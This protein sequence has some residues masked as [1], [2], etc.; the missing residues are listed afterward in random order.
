MHLGSWRRH[1]HNNGWLSYRQLAEQLI[2]YVAEMGFTH[3]ELLPISEHPFDGSWGYQPIGLYSPTYRFGG[4]ED[5]L[6][7][8]QT[9]HKHHLKVILDWVPAHFPND[10]YGLIQFDGTALYEYA[11]PREGVHQ[12]WHT[13]IYNYSRYEVAN[14]WRAMPSIG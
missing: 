8:I 7:L 1:P 12:N 4:I 3:L 11:D 14:F 6:Y 2:P 10:E 9:A 5:F 13:L